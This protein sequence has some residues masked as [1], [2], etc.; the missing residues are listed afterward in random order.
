MN[1]IRDASAGT[2]DGLRSQVGGRGPRSVWLKDLFLN[3]PR[4]RSTVGFGGIGIALID[5]DR[6]E[7]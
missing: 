6:S 1:A 2:L 3:A 7:S 5:L 4:L